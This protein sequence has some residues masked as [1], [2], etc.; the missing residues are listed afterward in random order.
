MLARQGRIMAWLRAAFGEDVASNRT[1]RAAR[2]LEEA[3]ELAQ[4]EGLSHWDA[5]RIVSRVY[6]QPVGV[7]QREAAGVMVAMLGWAGAAWVDLDLL[8]EGEIARVESRDIEEWR[9]RH[10]VKVAQ[11]I[12][13]AGTPPAEPVHAVGRR[14]R[15]R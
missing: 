14:K 15:D 11:G 6:H 1:E 7:P 5:E 12:A 8:T 13:L 10:Q 9:R 2:V 4:A 3:A